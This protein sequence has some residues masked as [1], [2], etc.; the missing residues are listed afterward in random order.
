MVPS[1]T[2]KEGSA[3]GLPLAIDALVASELNKAEKLR[4][5]VMK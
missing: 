1:D 2:R 5:Y 3:Y 4:E